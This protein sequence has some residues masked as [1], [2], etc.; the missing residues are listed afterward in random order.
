MFYS[1]PITYYTTV[2]GYRSKEY[3]LNANWVLYQPAELLFSQINSFI[4]TCDKGRLSSF[5]VTTV[6]CFF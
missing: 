2:M 6:V 1:D 5:Y 4:F 3:A